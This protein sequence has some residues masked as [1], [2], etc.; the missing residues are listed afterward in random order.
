V[1]LHPVRKRKADQLR[2][3]LILG[4]DLDPPFFSLPFKGI[5]V[6]YFFQSYHY[7]SEINI[8]LAW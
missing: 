4:E 5:L 1:S 8:S 3:I 7:L 2:G 6:I